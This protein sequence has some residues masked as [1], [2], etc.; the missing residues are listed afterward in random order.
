MF[1]IGLLYL[2]VGCILLYVIIGGFILLWWF[3]WSLI[4]NIKGLLALN[5]NEP[6]ANPESWM[7]GD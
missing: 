7:F 6:I 2:V 4:R 3:I 5:R 1:W